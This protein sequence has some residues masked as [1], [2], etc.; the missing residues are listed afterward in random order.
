MPHAGAPALNHHKHPEH[1]RRHDDVQAEKTADPIGEELLDEH[2]EIEAML[3]KE[4]DQL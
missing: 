4:W 1:Y 3:P 2:A